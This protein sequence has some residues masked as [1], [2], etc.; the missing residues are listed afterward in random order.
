MASLSRIKG[1]LLAPQSEWDAV[2]R[3]MPSASALLRSYLLPLS[4][5][6]PVATTIGML[7]F[8]TRW[9]AEYGYSI[10]RDRAPFIAMATYVFQIASVYLLAAVLYLLARTERRAPSFLVALQVAVFGSI[11]VQLSGVFLVIPFGVVV[12]LI[13]MMYAFYLYYL[14][15]ERLIGVR[16]AD[17]AMFIGVTMICM[18]LLS[19]IIGAIASAIGIV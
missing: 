6:T 18:I 17:S 11:P 3:D 13:A 8:D 9:N 16:Q 14:G 7:F 15:A 1:I 10:L 2:A 12:S 4:L 5:L 19:S